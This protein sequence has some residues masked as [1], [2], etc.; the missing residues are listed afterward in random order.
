LKHLIGHRRGW[1][2]GLSTGFI[3]A[4][5]ATSSFSWAA[6][7]QSIRLAY[8]KDAKADRCPSRQ[9]IQNT[10]VARLGY[11]PFSPTGSGKISLHIQ[12]LGSGLSAHIVYYNDN[13]QITGERRLPMA[14][15]LCADLVTAVALTISLALGPESRARSVPR[16]RISEGWTRHVRHVLDPGNT[17]LFRREDFRSTPTRIH[18]GWSMALV[19]ETGST[20]TAAPGLS[21]SLSIG[22]RHWSLDIALRAIA[23]IPYRLQE[24]GELLVTRATGALIPCY[25]TRPLRACLLLE[26]GF[27]HVSP[28]GLNNMRPHLNSNFAVG[29]QGEWLFY[30]NRH[31]QSFIFVAATANLRRIGV[32]VDEQ[33]IWRTWPAN[34]LVGFGLGQGRWY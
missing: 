2:F 3:L 31:W 24:Q 15:G 27:S 16:P 8:T 30:S 22:G 1:S 13:D 4:I 21:L 29:V 11:N 5:L 9:G 19:A 32:F 20:P 23:P 10:I 18:L 12:G 14:T 6:A 26:A 34:F 25:R 7:P 33:Q 28:Q 17:L